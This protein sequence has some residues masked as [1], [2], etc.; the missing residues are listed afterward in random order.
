M[1]RCQKKVLVTTAGFAAFLFKLNSEMLLAN[2]AIRCQKIFSSLQNV[3]IVFA[4][5]LPIFVRQVGLDL[6]QDSQVFSD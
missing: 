1:L 4:S 5:F 6:I 3:K 2:K